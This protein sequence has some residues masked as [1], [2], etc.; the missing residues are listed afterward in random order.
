MSKVQ[1]VTDNLLVIGLGMIG[2]SVL[3]AAHSA[4]IC[5]DYYAY[6]SNKEMLALAVDAGILSESQVSLSELACKASMIVIAVPVL[7]F[8]DVLAELVSLPLRDD[9][10]ISDVASVKGPVFSAFQEHAAQLLPRF[11][12]AHPIAGSEQSGFAASQSNLLDG[13][14][15][16]ITPHDYLDEGVLAQAEAFWASLGCDLAQLPLQLHDQILA[17]TSH[18]PHVLAYVLVDALLQHEY[19][20]ELFE[21]AAGGFESISRT[22]SSDPTMWHDIFM[23]NK[24]AVLE[25]LDMFE[26]RLAVFRQ[27]VV[28]EQSQELYKMLDEAKNGRNA[29]LKKFHSKPKKTKS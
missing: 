13:R 6:D 8:A 4:E 28:N 7:S 29:F 15:L 3:R 1:K 14:K 5:A 12:P 10:I 26:A 2:G 22:A 18:L 24:E 20:G 17:S 25:S 27:Y 9:V 19:R 16:I 23:S 21:F 11:V